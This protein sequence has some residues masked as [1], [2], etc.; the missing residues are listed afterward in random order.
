MGVISCSFV[1]GYMLVPTSGYVTMEAAGL[2]ERCCSCADFTKSKGIPRQTEVALGVP[3][4][5]RAR[6]I[7]TQGW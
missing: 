6:I 4:R 2:S 1:D 3:G 5:L 7:S